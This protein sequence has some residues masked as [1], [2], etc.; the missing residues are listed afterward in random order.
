MPC[1]SLFPP[2]DTTDPACPV[3]S[4]WCWPSDQGIPDFWLTA[5]TNHDMLG[6][7][8]T[9]RDA[10]VLSY[11]TDVR[12]SSLT[13]DDA[14]SFRLEFTF[15]E[16]PFFTN[17]VSWRCCSSAQLQWGLSWRQRAGGQLAG[18]L[19]ATVCSKSSQ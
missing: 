11:L 3:G 6:E 13:G 16:N 10:A 8:V 14:G 2:F 9:E 7:Y 4:C 18:G 5:I 12:V 1:L 15:K 17:K 19:Q